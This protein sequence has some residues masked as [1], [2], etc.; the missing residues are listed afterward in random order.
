[1]ADTGNCIVIV[2][3]VPSRV[4]SQCGEASYDDGVAAEL[5]KIVGEARN[6]VSEIIVINYVSRAA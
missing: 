2:K 4:C 6:A 1:M 3:N 5:E